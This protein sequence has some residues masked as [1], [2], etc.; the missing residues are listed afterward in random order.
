MIALSPTPFW[1]FYLVAGL[2]V[3]LIGIDKSGF[4]GGLGTLATPILSL[5]ISPLVAVGLLLP[6]LCVCDLFA[7]WHYRTIYDRRNLKTMIPGALAGIALGGFCLWI[8]KDQKERTEQILRMTIGL[9][10]I[11][12]A[13]Y[14]VGRNWLMAHLPPS[15][16][17]LWLGSLLGWVA[18]FT[19]TLAH[20]G[21]PPVTM[22][23][24]PQGMDRRLYVGTTVWFFTI[25]N[26]AKLIPYGAMG[27][28]RSDNFKTSL[29]LMPLAPAGILLGIAFN[30]WIKQ[31]VFMR[32]VLIVL[33]L[34]GLQLLSGK[35]IL[36]FL[37]AR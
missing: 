31:E 4:G 32:V 13:I 36:D 34:T 10:S 30:R 37:G 5:V 18:G 16:P 9:I 20:A 3:I 26:Y 12:F 25:V 24:L 33:F 27:M 22:Y 21:G 2:C 8:F 28:I 35:N 23:L 7:L 14:Q 17:R 11:L 1:I 6:I 19:S 15:R 29:L